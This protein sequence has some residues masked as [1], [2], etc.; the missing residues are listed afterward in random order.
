MK[1]N[2]MVSIAALRFPVTVQRGKNDTDVI[3]SF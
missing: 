2:G 1:I 3:R